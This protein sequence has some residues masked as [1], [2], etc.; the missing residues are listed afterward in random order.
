MDP[1]KQTILIVLIA[2]IATAGIVFGVSY[3]VFAP[4]EEANELEI[5]HWWTSGGEAAAV[6]A[7]VDVFEDKYPDVTVKQRALAGGSGTTMIPIIT[8][9]VLA[10][11]A[12]DA[13]QMHA[14]YEGIEY[15]K[16]DLLDDI[17]D[18]IPIDIKKLV[19]KYS[20]LNAE[21]KRMLKTFLS[22]LLEHDLTEQEEPPED[23]I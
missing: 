18:K 20:K 1:K 4:E 12:P 6:G 3:F 14:G 23:Y 13:F 17:N 21:N 11:E 2:V 16:A 22:F 5:Y 8:S 19:E 9:L 15:F 7:L 10:G